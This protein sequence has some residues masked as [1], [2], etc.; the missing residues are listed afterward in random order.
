MRASVPPS[1]A[2]TT[3]GSPSTRPI[4]C[5]RARCGSRS[6][7]SG[8]CRYAARRWVG[9]AASSGRA[10]SRARWA[11][12][13]GRSTTRGRGRTPRSWSSCAG[14]FARP[15]PCTCASRAA[16]TSS[17]PTAATAWRRRWRSRAAPACASTSPTTGRRR[18]PPAGSTRIMELIDPARA[19]GLDVTFDVYP[20][21]SGSSIAVSLLPSA[22]QEGGPDAILARLADPGERRRIA[23]TSTV[24]GRAPGGRSCAR[25]LP[26]TGARGHEPRRRR[27]REG[28]GAGRGA[29]RDA[30]RGASCRSATSAPPPRAS[31][32]GG[33]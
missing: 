21:P 20:Y 26:R 25:T 22:A 9:P 28:R 16:R 27:R 1:G 19:D 15:G 18:R 23:E 17:G 11:S 8:T 5:R 3:G 2:T 29:L 10:S 30:A 4:W 31:P 33:R 12:P 6:W 13:R 7:A 24:T 32:S 14:S